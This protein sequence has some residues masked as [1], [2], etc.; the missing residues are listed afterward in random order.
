M[1]KELV[2]TNLEA[3][4]QGWDV[5]WDTD[6]SECKIGKTRVL[7]KEFYKLHV[8]AAR[9]DLRPSQYIPAV[10]AAIYEILR[11]GRLSDARL[12]ELLGYQMVNP[13]VF[14]KLNRAIFEF[15]ARAEYD[16][17]PLLV[18]GFRRYRMPK[19]GYMCS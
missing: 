13:R 6:I 4:L 11:V 17:K 18:D 8:A 15:V 16:G 5:K 9:H 19:A 10:C 7:A 1:N 14:Q 2:G 12:A 3:I